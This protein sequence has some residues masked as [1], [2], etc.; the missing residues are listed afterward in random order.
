VAVV[1]G[2]D[3][4]LTEARQVFSAGDIDPE[5]QLQERSKENQV[6]EDRPRKSSGPVVHGI[7]K[8]IG[9]QSK[10]SEVMENDR[11]RIKK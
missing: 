8:S 6:H 10:V 9:S 11:R 3:D 4:V 5:K 2:D 1:I 7:L